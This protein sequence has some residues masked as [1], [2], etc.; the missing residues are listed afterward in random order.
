M[1]VSVC[2]VICS[3]LSFS[4][5]DKP[6]ARKRGGVRLSPNPFWKRLSERARP[7]KKVFALCF[8]H[9][10]HQNI[11][12]CFSH[13]MHFYLI[14]YLSM[15]KTFDPRYVL[16]SCNCI[17][18]IALPQLSNSTWQ[19]KRGGGWWLLFFHMEQLARFALIL[20]RWTFQIEG[21]RLH[22]FVGQEACFSFPSLSIKI[23]SLS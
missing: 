23:K 10:N 4:L 21:L 9:K 20:L 3:S 7:G 12:F 19:K 1:S 13:L 17:A 22:T 2:P 11:L 14:S 15:F 6:K 8:C 18:D 16:P 5:P